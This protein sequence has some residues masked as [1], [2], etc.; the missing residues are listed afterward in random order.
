[1]IGRDVEL[2]LLLGVLDRA[3]VE[4]SPEAGIALVGGDAGIGKTRLVTE[5]ARRA[6]ER[7]FLVLVGHCAELGDSFPYLPFVDVFRDA[8]RDPQIAPSFRRAV[9]DRPVLNRLLPGATPDDGGMAGGGGLAQQ[10]LFGAVLGLLTD[11]A[12]ERPVLLV[13]EDL[14]WADRS[15][16]DLLTFLSRVLQ[17]ERVC[18]V[19]TYRADDLHRRHPLRPVLAEL[20]RLPI[21]TQF[22][23]P[24]LNH[25]EMAAYLSSLGCGGDNEDVI[26]RAEGNPFYAEELVAVGGGAAGMTTGLS[27]LLFNR[28]ERLSEDAQQVLRVAAVAGR[29]IDDALVRQVTG[30]PD[31]Q[32]DEV[33]REIVSHQLL[34][35]TGDG[36]RFRHALL[37]E[38]VYSD[39]LPG[40]RTRL[41]AA[42][43]RILAGARGSAAELAYHYLASHQNAAALAASVEAAREAERAGAPAEVHRHLEQ[44]IELWES[45]PDPEAQAGTDAVRLALWSAGAA[46]DSG[47]SRRAAAQLRRVRDALGPDADP[48]V[49]AEVNERLA[50]Y[51][52]DTDDQEFALAAGWAAVE[53]LPPGPPTRVHADAYATYAR[54]LIWSE[55]HHEAPDWARKALEAAHATGAGGAEAGALATL[56]LYHEVSGDEPER[57]E[58]LLEQAAARAREAG[59]LP[60]E[61]RATFHLARVHFERGHLGL[62]RTTADDGVRLALDTGLAWSNYGNDLRFLQMLVHYVAGEWD[63]AEALA[64]GF[65]IRVGSVPEAVLSSFALFVEVARGNPRAAERLPWLAR[66]WHE[67]YFLAYLGRGLNAELELWQG[68]PERALEHVRALIARLDEFD[69][70]VLRISAIG[71]GALAEIARRPGDPDAAREAVREADELIE[72]A[73]RTNVVGPFQYHLGIESVA[74]LKRAEAEWLRVRGEDTPEVW[75]EVTD[76]FDFG[77][78]YEVARSRWRLAESLAAGDRRDEAREQWTLAVNAADRLGAAPL[79][80]A[81]RAFG[82]RA[83]LGEDGPGSPHQVLPTLTSREREVLRLVAEGRNNREVA[84]ALFISPKTASVHVSNILAKLGVTSRTSAAAIAHREGLLH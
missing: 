33:L 16:R 30:L 49:R 39:L 4:E 44:A 76:A 36:Y 58:E 35:P 12:D 82:R 2:G 51:V 38:A 24:P 45:V 25:D 29:T 67:S 73:R 71:L 75:R 72:R 84:A 23:V 68:R 10:Q 61:L 46:A 13:L 9:L 70:R 54:A 60:V 21:V 19:G 34:T 55:K 77:Y 42:F 52:S 47:G 31:G 26:E 79:R 64:D 11:L 69:D 37:R 63:R 40:E 3:A 1:M 28:V 56:A 27:A 43:A 6:R 41:H 17:R 8:M 7:G 48:L 22:G 20:V 14:H 57:C 15:T 5:L 62:A 83:R 78:V 53:A 74:W 32:Y 81:L 18:L 65:A 66:M 80:E 50:Y 59:D